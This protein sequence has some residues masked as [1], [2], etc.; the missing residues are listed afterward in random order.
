MIETA[1]FFILGFLCAVFIGIFIAPA[2]FK[3]AYKRARKD[4]ETSLP[5]TLEEINARTD[6]LRARYAAEIAGLEMRIKRSEAT[7]AEL[8][9]TIGKNHQELKQIPELENTIASLTENKAHLEGE[10]EN[11]GIAMQEQ[12]RELAELKQN[13]AELH[14]LHAELKELGNV[15]RLELA[16]KETNNDNLHSQIAE[17]RRSHKDFDMRENKLKA[18]ITAT[19]TALNNEKQKNVQLEQRL[20]R[21]ITLLSDAEEKLS[22]NSKE[23]SVEEEKIREEIQEIAAEMVLSSVE[24]EGEQSPIPAILAKEAAVSALANANAGRKSKS[25]KKSSLAKRIDSLSGS[26]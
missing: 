20:A 12:Q 11:L 24:Q 5:L 10:L 16:A 15:T 7:R 3:R 17:L 4:V 14:Q 19:Q 18:E 21:L 8:N 2:L 25:R 26:R 6:G 13:Y 23:P 1:L 9:I 22:R